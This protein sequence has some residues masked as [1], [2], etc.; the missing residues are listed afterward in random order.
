[1]KKRGGTEKRGNDFRGEGRDRKKMSGIEKKR[2]AEKKGRDTKNKYGGG[3]L[4]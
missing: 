3:W 2:N 1:M 4:H